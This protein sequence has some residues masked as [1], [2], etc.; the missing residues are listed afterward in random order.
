MKKLLF[1]LIVLSA[2]LCARAQVITIAIEATVSVVDDPSN[3]L[4]GT[5][6]TDDIITGT[7]TYSTDVTDTNPLST[8]G[9]YEYY[10]FPYGIDLTC[11]GL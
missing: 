8:V 4:E 6:V 11:N 1:V 9:D 3:L 7:Y 10:E 5:I 2:A